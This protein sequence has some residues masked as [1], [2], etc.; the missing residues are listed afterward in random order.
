MVPSTAGFPFLISPPH[1]FWIEITFKQATFANDVN[2]FRCATWG[3]D[4]VYLRQDFIQPGFREAEVKL[5]DTYPQQSSWP[6]LLLVPTSSISRPTPPK[7]RRVCP[8]GPAVGQY[9]YLPFT[10]GK[11]RNTQRL[12][13]MPRITQE[14]CGWAGI[15]PSSSPALAQLLTTTPSFLKAF[16]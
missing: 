10:N 2:S 5:W 11:N 13:S 1:C 15:R 14:A 3:W 16:M 4:A 12:S 9:Y 7:Q 8:P 6:R